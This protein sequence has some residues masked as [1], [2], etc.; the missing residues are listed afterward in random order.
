V[1]NTIFDS[2]VAHTFPKYLPTTKR[3]KLQTANNKTVNNKKGEGW[4]WLI[5]PNP[6]FDRDLTVDLQPDLT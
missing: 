5:Q 6:T 3:Q 1:N 2:A 4:V